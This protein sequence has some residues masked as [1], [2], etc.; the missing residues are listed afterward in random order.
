MVERKPETIRA[1]D[2]VNYVDVYMGDIYPAI[3]TR[4]ISVTTPEKGAVAMTAFQPGGAPF[5]VPS[6]TF[7]NADRKAKGTWHFREP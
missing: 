5:P 1:G 7:Y 2:I 6:I 4:V 3:V